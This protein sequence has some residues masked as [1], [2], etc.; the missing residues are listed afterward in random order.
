M[1]LQLPRREPLTEY[2]LR[3]SAGRVIGMVLAPAGGLYTGPGAEDVLLIRCPP[4]SRRT[5]VP[6]AA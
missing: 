3:D 4:R 5:E 2:V 6:T 1:M